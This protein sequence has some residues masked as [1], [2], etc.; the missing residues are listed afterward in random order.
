MLIHTLLSAAV[1]GPLK[2]LRELKDHEGSRSLCRMRWQREC[3][4]KKEKGTSWQTK[5]GGDLFYFFWFYKVISLHN[6][7][8]TFLRTCTR[9]RWSLH[10]LCRV[11]KQQWFILL[12][13]EWR[14][15]FS[16]VYLAISRS[17]SMYGHSN[18]VV[19]AW[20]NIHAWSY[21]HEFQINVVWLLT[22]VF[23]ISCKH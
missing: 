6:S 15:V 7:H 22:F 19:H 9:M 2:K 1:G 13:S 21:I 10:K 23:F 11:N 5:T 4:C 12:G 14:A 18:E 8:R 16:L 3:R 20:S 17:R